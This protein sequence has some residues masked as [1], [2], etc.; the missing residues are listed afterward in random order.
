MSRAGL[1]LV[2]SAPRPPRERAIPRTIEEAGYPAYVEGLARELFDDELGAL[3]LRVEEIV[4]DRFL[5]RY[6]ADAA[7]CYVARHLD[8]RDVVRL[9]LR[10]DVLGYHRA[11]IR[12]ALAKRDRATA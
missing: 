12:A 1:A 3:D 2:K 7:L 9:A 5:A 8:A 6:L 4:G 11:G 10:P